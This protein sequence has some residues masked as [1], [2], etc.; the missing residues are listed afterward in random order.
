MVLGKLPVPGRSTNLD[1]SGTRA[2]CACGGCSRG[3]LHIFSLF[4][5]FSFF[6]LSVGDGSK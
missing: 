1:N 2:S 3:C 6:P 4:C 5:R